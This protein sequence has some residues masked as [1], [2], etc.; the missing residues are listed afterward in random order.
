MSKDG[1]DECTLL[2]IIFKS[3]FW[4]DLF[5]KELKPQLVFIVQKLKRDSDPVGKIISDF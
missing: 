3:M 1:T 2:Q 5:D 4:C